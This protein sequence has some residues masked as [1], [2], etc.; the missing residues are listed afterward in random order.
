MRCGAEF[1]KR[2]SLLSAVSVCVLTLGAMDSIAASTVERGDFARNLSAFID[3]LRAAPQAPPGFVAVAVHGGDT[4]FEQAYGA[5]NLASREPLSLD[6]P[7]YN[8]STTKAYTGLLA[9]ILDDQ[10]LLSLDATLKDVWPNIPPSSAFD[11]AAIRASAL[12]AHSAGIHE[13]GIQVRSNITGDITAADVPRRL[14]AYAVRRE[15]GFRYANFGPYV[16][17]TMMEAKLGVPWREMVDRKVFE[18]LELGRTSARLE[19][20]SAHE[21]A[22]CHAWMG[23]RWQLAPL[24]PTPILNAAGG[25]Y[26][27]GRDSGRFLKAFLTDGK[28]AQG[29]V[30]AAALRRSWERRSVQ[31][32]DFFG[33]HRDGY[34]LGWDLGS[35]DDHRFVARS[36]G[37][38]GCRSIILFLPAAEFGIVVLSL[39]DAGANLL[40]T[41]IVKQAIDLWTSSAQA[42]ERSKLRVAEFAALKVTD[43]VDPRLQRR[44]AL[45][46]AV[47]AAAVGMYENERL[48]RFTIAAED[49]GLTISGGVFAAELVPVARDEFLVV[50]RAD[51]ETERFRLIRDAAGRVTAFMWDD[52]QYDRRTN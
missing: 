50:R 20:F 45:D 40:N 48:G 28:S 36:G 8:A 3:Q 5:R 26:T 22:R 33:L 18:P 2:S 24:K 7:I 42:G 46:E 19:D 16:W 34:G 13:G 11:P 37:A 23:G 29:R 52:D 30:T 51:P 15:P 49:G 17:S 47:S 1:D 32:R 14:A 21:V 38:A 43:A 10:G 27:S 6:T 25:I 12:L 4:V 41:S 35:Y 31:D 44:P 39:G 9:A